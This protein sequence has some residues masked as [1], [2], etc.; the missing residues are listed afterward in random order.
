MPQGFAP[1]ISTSSAKVFIAV[2]RRSP[3]VPSTL[4]YVKLDD[5]QDLYLNPKLHSYPNYEMNELDVSSVCS[6][7]GV[8]FNG[9]FA[10]RHQLTNNSLEH[11]IRLFMFF[12]ISRRISRI[13]I[14][15]YRCI[16]R[17]LMN[18]NGSGSSTR[19]L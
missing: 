18:V 13:T 15:S 6:G 17:G 3:G 7:R 16:G 8:V 4:N 19:E 9:S 12:L 1:H 10:S 14:E 2:P 5:G 11:K